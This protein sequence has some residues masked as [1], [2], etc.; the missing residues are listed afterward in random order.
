VHLNCH[1]YFS[2]RYGTLSP[3][4]LVLSAKQIGIRSLALTDVNNTSAAGEFV[5]L[6]QRE[7]IKPLLG[8]DFFKDGKRL[9]T[10]IARNAEGFRQLNQYLSDHSLDGK[11]LPEAFDHSFLSPLNPHPSFLII[12]PRLLKPIEQF[13]E[14]EYLGIRPE[15]AHGLFSSPVRQHPQKLLIFNPVTFLDTKGYELHQVLR[16]IDLNTILTKLTPEDTA[17]KT[18]TLTPTDTLESFYKLYPKIIENTQKLMDACHIELETGLQVNRQNF[19]GSK[20]GDF[21]LLEKLAREG[22]KRRFGNANLQPLASNNQRF[23][24]ELKLIREMDFCAYF[25]ITW[26]LVRYAQTSGCHHVGRGSGANSLVAYCLGIT[27]VDPLE[28]DLYFERFINPHRPSPPDFDIDFS[29]DERD[30]VTDY[31]FKRYGRGHTALLAT[32]STFQFNAAIREV[33]KVFGLPKA[34]IDS[35][36]DGI[37]K[38]TGTEDIKYWRPIS[39]FGLQDAESHQLA[40]QPQVSVTA[41]TDVQK[42]KTEKPPSATPS[43]QSEIVNPK[44]EI[45]KF[46]RLLHDF[47]NHLSIHA[48]GVVIS[49]KPIFYHTALQMMP[50]GFPVSHFDMHH[51]EDLGFHK[52]DVLSQRGLGHIKETVDLVKTNQGKAVDIHDLP[53]IKRDERVRAQLRGGNC[54][55]CFY[56]ESPAMRGLLKKLRCDNY[57]HLVAASSIIRPGV[58]KS[59]MMKEYIRR[60]HSPHSFE[61]L[62][63]VF[64]EH[65]GETFGVMVF[66]EDVMKI[67]HH[68]ANLG[69]DEGDMLRRLMSGKRRSGDKFEVLKRKYFDNCRSLGHPEALA[70][71]VWRQVESF[72]G[73]SFCKA[74]SAS[75]AVESFQ[76]LYLKAYFPLE[77]MVAVINNFGGFYQT[78]IYFHEVRMAGASIHAPCVNRSQRLTSITGTDVFTGFIHVAQ[79]EQGTVQR[80]LSERQRGAAFRSLADFVS[81]VDISSGQLDILIRIGAFRF[82]G[83]GKCALMWEKNAVFN[84]KERFE[85]SGLLFAAEEVSLGN[86]SYELP[87]LEE[88][89]FDQSFDEI[90]LLGFP[91]RS[92]FDLLAEPLA[93]FDGI[94]AEHLSGSVGRMATLTGYYVCRK[95]VRTVKG[96]LMCFGTWLDRE[97]RFFDTVHFPAFLKLSP[98]RGKGIYRIE[99]RVG[100][101]FG[102][103]SVEVL[104][105]ERLPFRKDGRYPED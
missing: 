37:L 3:E 63:P 61:Y 39:D 23:E 75:Y 47:P 2:L 11:P 103:P 17:K 6:C 50:K 8:I 100:E 91:L 44:S 32:Y 79:L 52:F 48:G 70:Q 43:P 24:R 51:A 9:Y 46:A 94:L 27:D 34:E 12:Y 26:D 25:L 16:A 90:E 13:K 53:A 98:F 62:H 101:E 76:S 59:G 96:E 102:F 80:L 28:L 85:P 29:W 71:E 21:K 57:P 42:L 73:Y 78:E 49:E 20:D 5:R 55:G 65:L 30:D 7:G 10:G 84:P 66:Q 31:L 69:L 22:Y 97:G 104:K 54:I 68:F 45:L 1:T 60:F 95:D 72:A 56:V 105:M 99:G 19:T 92:P 81:R 38:A 87:T 33:G 40:H 35:L 18:E 64:K 14:Y 41:K 77:F 67:V 82:T 58:S 93:A 89:E 74:H 4:Q 83:M 88:S 36:A 15:H 86:G